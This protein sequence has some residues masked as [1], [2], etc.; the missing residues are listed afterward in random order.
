M[1]KL[2]IIL[3]LM[4]GV[5]YAEYI[6]SEYDKGIKLVC[7]YKVEQKIEEKNMEYLHRLGVVQGILIGVKVS[8]ILNNGDEITLHGLRAPKSTFDEYLKYICEKTYEHKLTPTLGFS[9]VFLLNAY[10]I[11]KDKE[12]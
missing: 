1:T 7:D 5:V 8:H 4:S 6:P 2:L 9:E 10:E 12:K 3:A 11:I